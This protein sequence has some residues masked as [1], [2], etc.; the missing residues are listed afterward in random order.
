LIGQPGDLSGY[1]VCT[2]GILPG[3]AFIAGASGSIYMYHEDSTTLEKI[4][5]VSGKVGDMLAVDMS[6]SSHPGTVALFCAL[7]GQ[8]KAQLLH[9]DITKD[10]KVC[11]VL[12]VPIS[13]SLTG[14]L[15]TSMAYANAS[16][17][18][19]LILGFRRGSIAVYVIREDEITLFRVIG[20]AH[21]DETV[22]SLT[23]VA[24]ATNSP[25]GHLLAVGRDGR[26]SIHY[27]DLSANLVELVHN[28]PLPFGPN[29][30]G[31]YLQDDRILV[32]GFSSKKWFLY[33]VTA[34]EEV[35]SIDTGG[36]HRSWAFH[37][38]STSMGG[39]L[40]WTRA[41]GMHI[42]SQIGANHTVIRPGGHGR[43]IKAI[44][45]SPNTDRELDFRLI[46]TGAEDTD[47]KIFRYI[48][49]TLTPQRTLR[50]HTTG[51][52]HLQWSANGDYLFSSGGC[53]ECTCIAIH[54]TYN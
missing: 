19:F 53:E 30:E 26:L 49:S 50:K 37:P 27:I 23:W 28:L 44:A 40:V 54:R 3:I 13:E 15:A 29:L 31:L 17:V 11:R 9:V 34:E 47:I 2:S 33:D 16:E 20:K 41:S 36:A 43:E 22:T 32:H 18:D 5:S 7:V 51:I 1:S 10:P 39:T 21:D 25:E 24:L 46:A 52:Q 4:H 45:V 8:K 42:Y 14:S 35:M 38:H 6:S 12:H 48:D